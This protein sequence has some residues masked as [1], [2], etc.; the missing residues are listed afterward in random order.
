MSKDQKLVKVKRDTKSL[1]MKNLIVMAVL[2]AIALTGVISWFTNKTEATA[3]GINVI[4]EAPDGLEVA[5]VPHGSN[6]KLNYQ[7]GKIDLTKCE[8]LSDLFSNLSFEELTSD[9][10]HFYKPKLNQSGSTVTVDTTDKWLDAED[11]AYKNHSDGTSIPYLSLDIY[12]RS[13]NAHTIVLG[14]DTYIKPN[15]D[16][17]NGADSGNKS[18]LGDFSKDCIVGAVRMSTVVGNEPKLWIPA[19]NILY[20]YDKGTVS[21]EIKDKNSESF[22]HKYWEVTDLQPSSDEQVAEDVIVNNNCDYKIGKNDALNIAL[23]QDNDDKLFK[24]N[25]TLNIWVDGEDTEAR[26]AM[27]GGKFTASI[28]LKISDK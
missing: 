28:K 27:V 17:L 24:A 20:D 5:I 12:M 18:E 4:C 10:L 15:S 25:F 13:K 22:K 1:V 19:P 23:S 9:G 6:E 7:A 16:K 3:D 2:I 26:Q 21:T 8:S 11:Y 14:S